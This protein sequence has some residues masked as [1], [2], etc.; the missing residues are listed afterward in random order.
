MRRQ[1][2]T[3][4]RPA[5]E[6]VYLS[7][8]D[9]DLLDLKLGCLELVRVCDTW[10]ISFINS[11][12]ASLVCLGQLVTL[13]RHVNLCYGDDGC[14]SVKPLLVVVFV[15]HG[16][17]VGS[18]TEIYLLSNTSVCVVEYLTPSTARDQ[19]KWSETVEIVIK[20]GVA[21]GSK[22]FVFLKHFRSVHR[23]NLVWRETRKWR[24][25][26]LWF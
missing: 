22:A 20:S 24:M 18:G 2:F 1:N 9:N 7:R 16:M 26:C 14:N 23:G 19:V 8:M 15:E 21:P 11:Q 13:L 25:K 6:A 10:R 4:G 17:L 5:L 12:S 3:V